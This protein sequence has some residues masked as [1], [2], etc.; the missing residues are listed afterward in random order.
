MTHSLLFPALLC[1]GTPCYAERGNLTF[2]GYIQSACVGTQKTQPRVVRRAG[3]V[4]M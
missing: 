2:Q 3:F 1:P 4:A